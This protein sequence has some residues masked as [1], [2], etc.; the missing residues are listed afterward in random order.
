MLSEDDKL[1]SDSENNSH[2]KGDPELDDPG[3]K[4]MKERKEKRADDDS[5]DGKES[6]DSSGDPELDDPVIKTDS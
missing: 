3:W 2:D 6:E 1:S 4:A 5:G